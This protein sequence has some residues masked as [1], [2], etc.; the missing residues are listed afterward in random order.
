MSVRDSPATFRERER[1]RGGGW[2]SDV[3][4][5]NMKHAESFCYQDQSSV[6]KVNGTNSKS[7]LWVLVLLSH[8]LPGHRGTTMSVTY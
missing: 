1:E 2:T 8:Q 5:R 6:I 4:Y 3:S 7:F